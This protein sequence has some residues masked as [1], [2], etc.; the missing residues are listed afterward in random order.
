MWIECCFADRRRLRAALESIR[1]QLLMTN[2]DKSASVEGAADR[3]GHDD[4]TA[5]IERTAARLAVRWLPVEALTP[6]PRNA[7]VHVPRQVARIADSILAFGFN[8]PILI[9][10]K[11][12]VLAG[13]GRVL[14][15]RR[16]GLKE[17]PTITVDH[18]TESESRAFMIA[19]NRLAELASWDDGR[20][21]LELLELKTLDL[22]FSI[23]ATGFELSEIDPRIESRIESGGGRTPGKRKTKRPATPLGGLAVARAGDIWTLG[24]HRLVCG[25]D[26]EAAAFSAIDVAIRRWQAVAG[27]NARLGSS[28]ETFD[29]IARVRRGAQPE[30]TPASELASER[31]P[32]PLVGEGE[33]G[34]HSFPAV[35][36]GAANR[37]IQR[38]P[39]PRPAPT[40]GRP[41][42]C[43]SHDGLSGAGE[44]GSRSS[45]GEHAEGAVK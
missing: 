27:E 7:R 28:G 45:N 30:P 34:G 43:P 18:L 11:G 10:E 8:V 3:A 17:V 20:L 26:R 39:P 36:R 31:I 5:K 23:E 25:D 37:K 32:S 16:L 21:G 44:R 33:G 9:D 41:E 35:R 2:L 15:A 40:V 13:H 6:D 4:C 42:G 19:D 14:A 29:A 1:G 22:D 24:P 38:D 12:G